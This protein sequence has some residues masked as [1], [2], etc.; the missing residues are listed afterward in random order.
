MHN[1]NTFLPFWEGFSVIAIRPDGD[2]LLIDLILQPTRFPTC[3]GCR[4]PSTAIHEY[5]QRF[6]RDLPILGRAVRLNVE[7]RRVG[8]GACGKRME[9]VSWLDRYSRMTKRLAE[10]VIQAC[11]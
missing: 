8:C 9:A 2:D 11:Q 1:I 10:A 5:C 3:S 7:L 4:Q 6:I